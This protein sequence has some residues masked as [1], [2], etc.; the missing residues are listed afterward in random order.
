MLFHLLRIPAMCMRVCVHA[1]LHVCACACVC[2][3]ACACACVCVP[4]HWNE[5]WF[6]FLGIKP[7]PYWTGRYQIVFI[8][9]H[10]LRGAC[11]RSLWRAAAITRHC[12]CRSQQIP[13][14]L[15]SL[16][17]SAGLG[18]GGRACKWEL[19]DGGRCGRYH[20]CAAA[21]A[22]AAALQSFGADVT[23]PYLASWFKPG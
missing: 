8:C 14:P 10:S 3:W 12:E 15:L 9:I 7:S 21:A 4:A 2:A 16:F 5:L 11:R 23:L 17:C 1:W 19:T 6:R 18:G 13:P 20:T 22:A